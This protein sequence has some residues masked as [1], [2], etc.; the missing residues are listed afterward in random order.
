MADYIFFPIQRWNQGTFMRLSPQ[1]KLVEIHLRTS[2]AGNVIGFMKYDPKDQTV[3]L[4][5]TEEQMHSSLKE[6]HEAKV[7]QWDE[8]D[9]VVLI[10]NFHETQKVLGN[11]N[12]LKPIERILKSLKLHPFFLNW[13]R[14]TENEVNEE[15]GNVVLEMARNHPVYVQKQEEAQ[16]KGTPVPPDFSMFENSSTMEV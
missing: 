2:P 9:K 7:I 14:A 16:K 3:I 13:A 5:F 4:G 6:L 1:A 15:L 11:K 10:N 8:K 12:Y